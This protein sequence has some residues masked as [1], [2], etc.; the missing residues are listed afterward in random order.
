M[1]A[2]KQRH[3]VELQSYTASRDSF[4]GEIETYATYAKTWASI[5]PLSGR[6]LVYAQQVSEITKI[7]ITIRYNSSVDVKHRIKFGLRLFDINA[8]MD[9]E[10]R[11]KEMTLLCSE[12]E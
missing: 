10:E 11:N 3:K 12:A 5:E 7:R 6:E 8:I 2:G 9:T 1:N 4:G